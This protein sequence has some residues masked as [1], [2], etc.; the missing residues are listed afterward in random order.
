MRISSRHKTCS[1]HFAL[2]PD[3]IGV[4]EILAATRRRTPAIQPNP[5][6]D[7]AVA[8]VGP[9]WPDESI[10]Q[11]AMVICARP[12]PDQISE[13]AFTKCSMSESVWNGDGVMRN[14]SLPRGTVG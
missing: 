5:T 1:A 10:A 12:S 14:R 11:A 3:T 6:P 13:S 8:F 7:I 2:P 9:L 4:P